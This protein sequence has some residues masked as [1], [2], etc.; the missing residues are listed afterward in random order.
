MY[1]DKSLKES[2][3]SIFF[4]VAMA[5][6]ESEEIDQETPVPAEEVMLV[7]GET[8]LVERVMVSEHFMFVEY[9]PQRP[10]ARPDDGVGGSGR[11]N[12]H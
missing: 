11:A 12:P 4:R 1:M 9:V 8:T 3:Q 10:A 6:V 2:L 7:A 5:H